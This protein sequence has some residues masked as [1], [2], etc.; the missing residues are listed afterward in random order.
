MRHPGEIHVGYTPV[1][2][3]HTAHIS[4][5]FAEMTQKIDRRS[6]KKL[7]DNP[8]MI[9]TGDAAIVKLIPSKPMVVE[10]FAEFPPLG[11]SRVQRSIGSWITSVPPPIKNTF[12]FEPFH[13]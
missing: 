2:D 10:K 3:C 5:R 7:E 1:T 8:K 12:Q 4:C 6:G 13:A 9:K 11:E